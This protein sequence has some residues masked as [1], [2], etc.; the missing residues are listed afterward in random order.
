MSGAKIKICGL[1][2]LCDAD[3][4]NLAM[5]DYAGFVFYDKSRRFVALEQARKLRAEIHPEIMTAGVFVNAPLEQIALLCKEGII[6]IIQLHGSEDDEYIAQLRALVPGVKIWKAFQIRKESD[7]QAAA[8]STADMV[9]LDSGGGTGLQFDWSLIQGFP[10][11]L[12]L[13][14]GLTPENM[15]EAIG[16]LHPYALDVSTGVETDGFKNL[17]KIIAAVEAAR[18]S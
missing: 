15:A 2:R 4:V 8:K 9:L 11:P 13:A 16:R 12:I 6:S 7:L 18:R 1:V 5:P 3:Y 17:H 14:G 10:R